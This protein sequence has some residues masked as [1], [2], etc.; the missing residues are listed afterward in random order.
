MKV[1][2]TIIGKEVLNSSAMVVGRVK[3][4][5]VNMETNEIEALIIGKGGISESLGF[6]SGEVVI[7]YEM[8]KEIGDKILLREEI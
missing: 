7:P 1:M 5:E 8:V 2:E 6:S 3:D 4:I